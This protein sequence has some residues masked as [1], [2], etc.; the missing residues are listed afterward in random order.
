MSDQTVPA[1]ARPQSVGRVVTAMI[2]PFR[3]EDAALDL[4]GAQRLADHLVR[5][6]SDTVLVH[7]T[8]GESPTLLGEEPWELLRAVIDAVGDRASVMMGTGSN[9]TRTAIRSTERATALGAD[10]LLLVTPYYNR[11]DQRGLLQHFTKVAEH[12]DRPIVLYDIA[13]RTGRE[14]AVSTMAELAQIPH[15]IGVKDASHDGSK[16]GDVLN[17]TEGA[18]GGFDVWSGADEFNLSCVASGGYGIISVAAHLLG[19]ELAEMIRVLPDDPRAAAL[20]HR[21]TLPVTRALFAEPSPGP[22][23]GALDHLGLPGGPVRLPLADATEPVVAALLAAL[24]AVP[25]TLE[26]HGL[27]LPEAA[28]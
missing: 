3:H 7:G 22:L 23:K 10:S 6:G 19:R 8:T 14:I 16:I 11:P 5:N 9:D 12:T 25:T 24:D 1:A 2:T 17:A 26:R 21:A 4:D 28:A 13:V 15:V 18:P 27:E 20:W